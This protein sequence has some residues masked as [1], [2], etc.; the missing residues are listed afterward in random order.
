VWEEAF[1]ALKI[2]KV[3]AVNVVARE[4]IS[5]ACTHDMTPRSPNRV[6]ITCLY[7]VILV[8]SVPLYSEFKV[9]EEYI[10]RMDGRSDGC[11]KVSAL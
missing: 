1:P 8:S 5:A 3:P 11:T 4:I 7:M 10:I 2:C 6:E 9:E